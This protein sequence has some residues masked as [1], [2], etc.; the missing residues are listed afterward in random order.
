MTNDSLYLK[1]INEEETFEFGRYNPEPDIDLGVIL[2]YNYEE[3]YN[4]F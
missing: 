4:I 2:D 1:N 3:D